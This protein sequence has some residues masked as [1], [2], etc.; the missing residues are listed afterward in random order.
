MD[1]LDGWNRVGSLR[2]IPECENAQTQDQR[3]SGCW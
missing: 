2:D 1:V 3:Q